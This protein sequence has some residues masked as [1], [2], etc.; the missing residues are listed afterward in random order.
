ME[1]ID[2]KDLLFRRKKIGFMLI[3]SK[4]ED[5]KIVSVYIRPYVTEKDKLDEKTIQIIKKMR[6]YF[7][8][9]IIVNWDIQLIFDFDSCKEELGPDSW[10]HLPVPYLIIINIRNE[11][12]NA[13]RINYTLSLITETITN[14]DN[15][16]FD[17]TLKKIDCPG[18]EDF[19]IIKS[20]HTF[21][22]YYIVPKDEEL[23][24]RMSLY[25]DSLMWK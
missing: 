3:N 22:E 17:I 8:F 14:N 13:S 7:S 25:K 19:V 23:W 18:N 12:K 11:N 24:K 4:K 15:K 1:L 10:E 5:F 9:E 20:E 21:W 6:K 2:N 16:V